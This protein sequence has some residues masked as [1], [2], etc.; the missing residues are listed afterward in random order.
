MTFALV[1]SQKA[2]GLNGGTTPAINTTGAKLI[3]ISASYFNGVGITVS[4]SAGNTW[5]PLTATSNGGTQSTRL[6]YCIN[7]T[8]SAAHTF[9]FGSTNVTGSITV[10]AWSASG[11]AF[12][13][14]VGGFGSGSAIT[15]AGATSGVTPANNG[16][17]LLTGY[18]FGAQVSGAAGSAGWTVAV[19][20]SG[21]GGSHFG[22]GQLYLLQTTAAAIAALTIIGTSTLG[23]TIDRTAVFYEPPTESLSLTT[24]KA[25]EVHQ[26]IGTAGSIQISGTVAGTT[27]DIEASF[28]GGA[29]ATIAVAAAPGAFSGTLTGQAQGQGTLTVRKKTTTATSATVASVGIGD[30]FVVGGDSISEGRGTNPQSY[31]HATLKA[32]KFTQADAWG[33]GIDGIDAGTSAGSHWPLLATQIMASQGVPVA[34]ISVG[35]GSTDVAGAA[36]TWAKPGAEYSGLTGQVTDSTVAGVKAVLMHLG[37]N[38]VVNASTLSRATYNAAI[39]TLAANI[40]ADVAGA[41]KTHIGIFGEV[42]TGSPPDRTAALN[43]LRAAIIEAQGDNAN[44]KPGPCLVDLD[45]SDGVHPQSDAQLQAVAKRWWVALAETYYGG[46]GG[47]GPRL[48]AASWNGARTQLTVTFDRALKTGLTHSTACWAISD[49]G[50]AMTVSAI[51]YHGSNPNALIITTSVAAVGSAGTTTLTFGN[52]DTAVG[53]VVPLSADITM[54]SG[55]AIQIPAEPFYAAAVGEVDVTAPVITGPGGATGASS[56]VSVAENGTTVATFAANESVTWSLNGGAD[57][58]LFAIN[59]TTGALTFL[60]APN[61]EAPSDA[62]TNNVYLVGV[63][64]TDGSGNATTQ[65]VS[66]TVTNANEAPSFSGTISVP[67]LTQGVAMSPVTT[68]SLFADVDA[69][70]AGTYSAVGSWPPGVTVNAS[71]GVISGTPSAAGTYS[72]LQVRRTDVGSLTVDSTA[73]TITVTAVT[74]QITTDPLQD[75]NGNVLASVTIDKLIATRLSDLVQVCT[76]TAQTTN[77]AG[78]LAL[79]H[80]S[81]TAVPHV[82]T[83]VNAAGAAAGAK[84]YTPA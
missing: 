25:F 30:V 17:L 54:P 34:F 42:S 50:S 31:A 64:A 56:S 1:A 10:T 4:D 8:T 37:P 29:F 23:E 2:A 60:S 41:P 20:Q 11:V 78:V 69:G 35:T 40:A 32:A 81:L 24:P 71:T 84:V 6:F 46:S 82:L 12:D 75:E 43:N 62:D 52:G 33:D 80:A 13:K 44:V 68:A 51:A 3:V 47:R 77:G 48:S 65:T 70:D 73:F 74:L 49:N 15:V 16:S 61:F 36:N 28:N 38:A 22:N 67:A 5:T 79:P 21:A 7:P 26:R 19:D 66:V 18:G 83:T 27:E 57:V 59:A 39:D 14:E 63:R 72:G 53:Q 76:W 58:A 45:Y 55:A 9:T